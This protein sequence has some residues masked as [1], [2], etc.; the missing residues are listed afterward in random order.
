MRVEFP[1]PREIRDGQ[2]SFITAQLSPWLL[3]LLSTFWAVR[4]SCLARLVIIA[5]PKRLKTG[6][7]AQNHG[8]HPKRVPCSETLQNAA[9]LRFRTCV[10]FWRKTPHGSDM[11]NLTAASRCAQKKEPL[12]CENSLVGISQIPSPNGKRRRRKVMHGFWM[13]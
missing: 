3:G 7:K 6:P 8:T 9:N 1:K 13:C 4:F 2:E 11:K 5:C 10:R 12:D